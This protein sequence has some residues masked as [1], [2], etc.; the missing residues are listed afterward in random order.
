[1][2]FLVIK[3]FRNTIKACFQTICPI[4]HTC[5]TQILALLLEVCEKIVF[6]G[7]II[8]L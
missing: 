1:M 7:D 8:R 3:L 6:N 5:I 4:R 2:V